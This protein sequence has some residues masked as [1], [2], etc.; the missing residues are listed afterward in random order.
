MLLAL[1]VVSAVL[2]A[3]DRHGQVVARPWSTV[4]PC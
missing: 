3:G 4:W 2:S 1:G